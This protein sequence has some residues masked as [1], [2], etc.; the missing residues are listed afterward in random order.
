MKRTRILHTLDPD[1]F[2]GG[3]AMVVKLEDL[4]V[5]ILQ[6]ASELPE[7]LRSRDFE[8]QSCEESRFDESY[9]AFL[10]EQIQLS[11][12][13]PEW[14]ERLKRRRT[15]L[16]PYCRVELIS[17]HVRAGTSGFTVYVDPSSRE[18]V[19]CEEYQEEFNSRQ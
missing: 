11:P 4:F 7:G 2:D 6:G 19:Y 1:L 10:D 13:G 5:Q 3:G 8:V 15:G 17:G 14:A 12:R 16:A 9:I 18:V